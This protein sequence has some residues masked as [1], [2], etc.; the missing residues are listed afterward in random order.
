[1]RIN[2]DLTDLNVLVGAVSPSVNDNR[3]SFDFITPESEICLKSGLCI[4]CAD[5]ILEDGGYRVYQSNGGEMVFKNEEVSSI[6][7]ADEQE[8]T[9]FREQKKWADNF[10]TKVKSLT[11]EKEKTE[12]QAN[13]EAFL[14]KLWFFR[15]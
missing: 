12:A 8:L 14:K 2:P 13:F 3:I 15:L 10:L 9:I 11:Q 1:L 4:K 7:M 6:K 5:I